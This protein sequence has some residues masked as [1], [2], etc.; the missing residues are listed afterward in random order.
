[1][2]ELRKDPTR[3]RWVLIRPKPEAG[4]DGECPY[5]PGAEGRAT[6]IAA[7]RKDGSAPNGPGWSIRVVPASDP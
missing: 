5:C 1:V 4:D 3:G 2:E 7:Y 6:E